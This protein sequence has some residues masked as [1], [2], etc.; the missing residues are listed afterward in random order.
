MAEMEITLFAKKRQTSDGRKS[1]Y[2]F[3]TTLTR[4]D[5]TPCVC[6]V[7]FTAPAEEP[8]PFDCPMNI[9]VD[10]ADCN[11][12][13]EKYTDKFGVEKVSHKL[14]IKRY[15]AGSPYVDKSLDDFV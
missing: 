13:N 6:S 12:A 14:W 9:I 10:K 3:L 2:S 1:F 15:T 7:K 5:G 11:L 4:K 8:E